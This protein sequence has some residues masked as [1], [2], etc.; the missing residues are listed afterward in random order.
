MN[1]GAGKVTTTSRLERIRGRQRDVSS[2]LTRWGAVASDFHLTHW[3]GF[4]PQRKERSML[5]LIRRNHEEILIIDRATGED[6][7]DAAVHTSRRA[8]L[9]CETRGDG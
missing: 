8:R 1:Q 6:I 7:V 9:C 3:N 5:S 4:P 2:S